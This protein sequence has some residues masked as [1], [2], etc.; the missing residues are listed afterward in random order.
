MVGGACAITAFY[1][2]NVV[3]TR[4]QVST[5]KQMEGTVSMAVK[6]LQT[7]VSCF[8]GPAFVLCVRSLGGT[9]TQGMAGLFTGWSSQ[10]IALAASNFVYFYQ[11]NGMLG[12]VFPVIRV[13]IVFGYSIFKT[14]K[15][16][17]MGGRS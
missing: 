14:R 5:S 15:L 4:L 8:A 16:F 7:E 13:R 1:P 17:L 2:L 11:Y 3:R 6:I 9:L 10:V 12:A